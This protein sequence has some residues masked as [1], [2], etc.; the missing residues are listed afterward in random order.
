MDDQGKPG[1]VSG[2]AHPWTL[3]QLAN[4]P[5]W[6]GPGR[7]TEEAVMAT[8]VARADVLPSL[9]PWALFTRIMQIIGGLVKKMSF[10][11]VKVILVSWVI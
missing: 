1:K 10:A 4:M 5:C 8:A 2:S 3:S 9:G 6:S 7:P 11:R